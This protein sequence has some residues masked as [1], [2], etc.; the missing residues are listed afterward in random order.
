MDK[1]VEP[2]A[3]IGLG[4]RFP[5]ADNPQA[6]W[7]LLRDGVDAITEVPADRW[8]LEHYYDE[9]PQVPGK[10]NARWGGFLSDVDHF[11]PDFFGISPREA[12]RMDPQ[13]KLM[14]EVVWEALE[15]ANQPADKLA[16]THTGLFV[17]VMNDDHAQR[18]LPHPELVDP[19]LGAGSSAAIVANRISYLLDLQGPSILVNTLCSSSL[20]AVHLA[21]QSLRS[22]DS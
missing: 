22:G 15:D 1:T 9:S 20:V 7:R 6:F 16:G 4:C 3:I 8:L 5:G 17:G 14:L 12:V 18:H 2:I 19:Y 13:Q 10:T 21:C 11:D